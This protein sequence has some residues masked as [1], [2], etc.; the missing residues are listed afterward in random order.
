MFFITEKRKH[1]KLVKLRLFYHLEILEILTHTD[2]H[3]F[4]SFQKNCIY[5]LWKRD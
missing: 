5:K 1:I 4:T 2:G 3:R